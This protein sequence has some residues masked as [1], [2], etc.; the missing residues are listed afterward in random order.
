MMIS[1]RFS[2]LLREFRRNSGLTQQ[3]LADLSALS[4]RAVR[5]LESGRVHRPRRETVRLLVSTLRLEGARRAAFEDA[6]AAE[7]AEPPPQ[8]TPFTLL[9]RADEVRA[10]LELLRSGGQRLI[11][12]TGLP[13]VGKSRLATEVAERLRAGGW[14]ICWT[15]TGRPA[16][17]DAL[18]VLDGAPPSDPGIAE[19]LRRHPGL[20]VLA[21]ATEPLR[22]PGERVMPLAPLAAP[23][24]APGADPAAL[25][26]QDAVQ[27]FLSHVRRVRPGYQLAAGEVAV[28][29]ELCARLDGLPAAIEHA[30]DWCLIH[31]P[32]RLLAWA[33]EDPLAVACSPV[34]DGTGP[35]L[36]AAVRTATEELGPGPGQLLRLLAG[37]GRPRTFEEIVGYV[38]R[39]AAEVA[40]GVH[41]LL[42]RGLVRSTPGGGGE[43]FAVPRLVRRALAEL[44]L[45]GVRL[46]AAV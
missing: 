8:R 17:G 19:L 5:D 6:A 43:C 13:G 34:A 27:L 46:L 40:R 11:S 12:L 37:S 22:L 44:P 24:P 26:R 7:P 33:R 14:Q 36:R 18:L 9:G 42:L 20:R 10:L 23:R 31:P 45:P 28:V 21:T 38:G 32:H 3:E 35:D 16:P 39:P 4:V 15:A 1:V 29:A 30:A 25:L 2:G 41:A